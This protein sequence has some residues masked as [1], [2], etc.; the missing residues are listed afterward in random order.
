MAL[1][2]LIMMFALALVTCIEV[3][4]ILRCA[5]SRDPFLLNLISSAIGTTSLVTAIFCL[6]PEVD[7]N[8]LPH[9]LKAD[10]YSIYGLLLML[11]FIVSFFAFNLVIVRLMK[12]R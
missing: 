9:I 5:K 3:H 10:N 11:A 6:I 1:G 7:L 12:G 4:F 8:A 2:L